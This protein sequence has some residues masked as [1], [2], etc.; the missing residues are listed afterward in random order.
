MNTMRAR[1]L[2]RRDR[3]FYVI[4]QPLAVSCVAGDTRLQHHVRL[5]D[6]AALGIGRAR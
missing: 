1:I 4:L 5:D 2:V 6:V 3:R